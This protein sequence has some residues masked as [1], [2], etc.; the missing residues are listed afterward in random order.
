MY[1]Y[2]KKERFPPFSTNYYKIIYIVYEFLNFAFKSRKLTKLSRSVIDL[3]HDGI[4]SCQ[5]RIR[6]LQTI[7]NSKDCTECRSVLLSQNIEI[8]NTVVEFLKS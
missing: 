8:E 7:C 3:E 4:V 2:V 1:C 5:I 6:R